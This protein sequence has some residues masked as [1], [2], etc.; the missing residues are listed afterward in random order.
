[1]RRLFGLKKKQPKVKTAPV[2]SLESPLPAPSSNRPAPTPLPKPTSRSDDLKT[3]ATT[4]LLATLKLV[5][6]SLST[7]PLPGV[8]AAVHGLLMAVETVDVRALEKDYCS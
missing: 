5:E 1:M 6:V 3:I 8:T 7:L 4:G 2:S